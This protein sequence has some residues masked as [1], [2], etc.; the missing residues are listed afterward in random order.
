MF[1]R[2]YPALLRNID[3][4]SRQ[5]GG[6]G[7]VSLGLERDGVLRRI[8]AVALIDRD[9]FP[10]ISI[11]ML[12]VAGDHSF[13]TL[14]AGA[15][16][17]S[18]VRV[19]DR[20]AR[21]DGAGR[22]W[23]Y[24]SAHDRKRFVSAKSVLAGTADEAAFRDKLVLVGA[25][26]VG[27]GDLTATPTG[28]LMAGVEVHAQLI[29]N[30]LAGELLHRPALAPVFEICVMIFLGLLIISVQPRIALPWMVA[31]L[32][33]SATVLGAG[34]WL[35]FSES[36]VLLDPVY[37]LTSAILLYGIV[38]SYGLIAEERNKRAI[39]EHATRIERESKERVQ[40]LLDSTGGAAARRVASKAR[41]D[42]LP[43]GWRERT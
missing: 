29:E 13:I 5:S 22:S 35:A 43:S 25:T 26:A 4:L 19:G 31:M 27:L 16:G 39:A 24:Y 37:P 34:S 23:L 21:T 12:R 9:I 28:S 18:G 11:E 40:L 41:P 38:V 30:I 7:I 10:A 1:L 2:S 15:L 6:R 14:E 32:A 33:G 36:R 42:A 20:L 3:V 8:P 17:I